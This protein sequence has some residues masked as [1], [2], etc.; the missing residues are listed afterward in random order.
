MS[1]KVSAF[2]KVQP[3]QGYLAADHPGQKRGEDW[4]D[5]GNDQAAFKRQERKKGGRPKSRPPRGAALSGQFDRIWCVQ[6]VS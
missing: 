6:K 3:A 4:I 1:T 5:E 2:F